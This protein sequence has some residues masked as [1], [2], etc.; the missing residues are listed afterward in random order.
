[1]LQQCRSNVAAMLLQ[2]CS[3]VASFEASSTF[4]VHGKICGTPQSKEDNRWVLYFLSL[5]VFSCFPV[6]VHLKPRG[7]AL[8]EGF[9]IMSTSSALDLKPNTPATCI[10]QVDGLAQL[11][12][13]ARI[14]EAC[15]SKWLWANVKDSLECKE[16][17][18]T[19]KY[20]PT[21]PKDQFNLSTLVKNKFNLII[22]NRAL[23]S[24]F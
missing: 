5:L 4:L 11:L 20:I 21:N 7:S 10:S 9:G 23:R 12:E 15:T 24:H 8:R 19:L 6:L 17:H 3:N 16:P 18:R 22:W 1:M 13:A 2:C 14:P